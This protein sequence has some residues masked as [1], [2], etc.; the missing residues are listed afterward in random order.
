MAW[1]LLS[2]GGGGKSLVGRFFRAPPPIL[3]TRTL[4]TL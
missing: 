3:G 2:P 1:P 4:R